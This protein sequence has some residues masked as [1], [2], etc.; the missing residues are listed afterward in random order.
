MKKLFT[1]VLLCTAALTA[2]A[3]YFDAQTPC[4]PRSAGQAWLEK[5]YTMVS[6]RVAP[7]GATGPMR[8]I[9]EWKIRRD[10]NDLRLP[11][12]ETK[13]LPVRIT[14]ETNHKQLCLVS[15]ESAAWPPKK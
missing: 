11:A 9:F 6:E 5:Y 13:D 4:A 7:A 14:T 10:L 2:K 8:G 1:T 3:R 15:A 12:S